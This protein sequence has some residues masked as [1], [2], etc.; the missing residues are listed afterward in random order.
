MARNIEIKAHIGNIEVLES[1]VVEIAHRLLNQ[2]GIESSQLIEAA[3]VDMFE[4]TG[5]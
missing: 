1:K 4:Q 3:Y 2:L 5:S